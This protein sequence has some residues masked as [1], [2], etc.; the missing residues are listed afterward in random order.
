MVK[1]LLYSLFLLFLLASCEEVYYPDLQDVDSLLVIEALI[2]NSPEK[3]YIKISKTNNFNVDYEYN[4]VLNAE[5]ELI[6]EKGII[7]VA[8]HSSFGTYLLNKLPQVGEKYKLIVKISEE[9]YESQFQELPELPSYDSLFIEAET[10]VQD[11]I[12]Y[13]GVPFKKE[14]AGAQIY[15]DLPITE[16]LNHYRFN[17]SSVFLYVIPGV[18]LAPPTWGWKTMGSG[19]EFFLASLSRYSS[20]IIIKRQPLLFRQSDYK[21]FLT[22]DEIE[23]DAYGSGWIVMF[24]QYGLSE[25]TYNFYQNINK[26]LKAEG[27]LFDPINTQIDSNIKCVSHPG[28]KV[29]GYFEVSSHLHFRYYLYNSLYSDVVQYHKIFTHHQIPNKGLITSGYYP[30]FWE[31]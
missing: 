29:L 23:Q 24:D 1:K 4:P 31:N 14:V 7:T 12:A 30:Y 3:N 17:W 20:D 22:E 11:L 18:M 10:L 19:G 8:S 15:A 13:D 28:K 6:S 25:D 26:Q 16:K 9:V 5:V 27:K 21:A 2:T